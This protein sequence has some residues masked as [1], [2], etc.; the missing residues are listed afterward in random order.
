MKRSASLDKWRDYFRRG[1]SDIFGI[2]DHA[3]MVAA[4][5]CPKEFKSRRDGIAELLFSCRASRCIGCDH[6]QVLIPG[7]DEHEF[8]HC[9]RTVES[10]GVQV[11]R[12]K[13]VLL[14]KEDEPNSVLLECLRKLETMSMN[15]DILKDTEI[16]KAVNGLRRHGSDKISKLAKTLFAEWKELVDQWMNAPKDMAGAEEGG[17]PESANLSVID[18]E[19][20]FPSPPHDL[21]IYAPEPNGFELSQ[22]LDCLDCD[23]NPRQNNVESKHE[24]KLQSRE[25]RRP[26]GTNEANVVGRYNKDQQMRR[27][28]AEVRP[29]KHSATSFGEPRRQPKQSRE[30]MVPATQR[31][32]LAVVAEQKRKLAGHQQDKL[33][34]DPDTK[35]EFAKRRLQE[36]YQQHENAKRQRTIQVLETIPKQ[37]NVQKP[38]LKRPPPR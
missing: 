23:G 9:P 24:S 14:N 18:E 10:V 26:E 36:S 22:I 28:E 6:L 34:L 1:D 15:V 3:I 16:G 13:D 7:G 11:M 21:D 29:V 35:F 5:D 2:I 12:I 19:E 25:R 33:T 31:K 38:Q 37:R 8:E 30:R 27:K 32:P 20:A 4:S 17:T